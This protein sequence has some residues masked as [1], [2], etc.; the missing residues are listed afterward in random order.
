[1]RIV[2]GRWRGKRLT[3]PAGDTTRPT[4]DRARQAVF[5]R[6]LHAP[7]G[8]KGAMDG[9]T[10]LDAF[11]GS[12]ALG[13]E[14]LSRGASRAVFMERDRPA[15]A[16]IRA[17]LA[18]CGVSSRAAGECRIVAGDVLRPPAGVGC[19]IAFLDPP[20]RQHLVVP[21]V[22]ALRRAG[23]LRD[24]T[25]AVIETAIGDEAEGL[26]E[27]LASFTVGIAAIRVVRLGMP[28]PETTG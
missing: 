26:G 11:A 27:E 20:Y 1:M 7:W 18:S 16:A 25:I 15:L 23:W 17:N 5:D 22:A 4:A 13:L 2:G 3:V 9:A 12:G 19:G 8:G 6:L 24:G 21:A 14:A 10:V 28:G